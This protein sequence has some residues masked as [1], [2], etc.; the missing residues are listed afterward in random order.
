MIENDDGKAMLYREGGG[1][2]KERSGEDFG[3]QQRRGFRGGEASD[4]ELNP[5]VKRS[6]D[7]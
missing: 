5:S 6:A 2:F 4:T 1:S 3:L 7:F